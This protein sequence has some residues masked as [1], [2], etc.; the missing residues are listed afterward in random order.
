MPCPDP[1]DPERLRAALIALA[2]RVLRAKGFVVP[3]G[4]AEEHRLVVQACGRTVELEPGRLPPSH[5]AAPPPSALV[6]IGLDDLPDEDELA[7]AVCRASIRAGSHPMSCS[8]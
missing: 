8:G 2:P 7:G 5:D 3:A 6:F 1:I 4:G